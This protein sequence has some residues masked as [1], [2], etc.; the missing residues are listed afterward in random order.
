MHKNP[1]VLDFQ[2][3]TPCNTEVVEE[4][5]PYWNE[6]WG[7]P[8]NTNHRDGVFA[9]A[10][11]EVS[12]EKIA[13]FL[14]IN[15]K[16][17]IFTSGA[18]ES[19]NLSLLGYA[20]AKEK[21]IGKRGHIITLSTEHHAVLNPLRQLQKAGFRLTE[22]RPNK[23]G[24]I[25]IDQLYEACE[26][27]TFLV[28]IMSANN[29]IGVLQP[30]SEI[31]DFC[32]SKGIVFH[33]DAAQALGYLDLD[34]DKFFIDLMSLSAHKIYGPKGIGALVIKEGLPLEPS[35]YGGGQELGL[36]SGTLP[37]PLIVGFAKAVEITKNDQDERNKKLFFLRNLLFSGLKQ[38]ISGLIL[39]GSFEQRLPHNLNITFPG[40]NGIRLHSELRRF[41][42]CTSGSACS[43]GEFS[44]VLQEIGV[45]K[46]DAEASIRMSIG[47]YT[48]EN[49]IKDAVAIITK[50]VVNLRK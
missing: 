9:S 17:L 47:R 6:F 38:N 1:L 14:N 42:F 24:L 27:D 8:S 26:K 3:S 41:I 37:V 18:T 36:R 34:P 15:P 23:D 11:V 10:A 28:S 31:G 22:L 49:D 50:I 13:S 2:S 5:A 48:T 35:Q 30:I 33:T 25:N 29:E 16:R 4:M 19:N 44:H 7:N 20:R 32:K 46:R 21:L 12:R 39:N 45:S 40:V 43:N